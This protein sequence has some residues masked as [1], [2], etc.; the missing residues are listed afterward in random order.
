M[1]PWYRELG[2]DYSSYNFVFIGSRLNEPLLHHVMADTRKGSKRKPQRGYLISPKISQLEQ[3][4]LEAS[5]IVH[6][7]GTLA[8]F[9]S[10]LKAEIGLPPTGWELATAKRPELKKLNTGLPAEQQRALNSIV[11]VGR[12]SLPKTATAAGA[13]RNFYKGFKPSW[14]DILDGVQAD[15][16]SHSDFLTSILSQNAQGSMLALLGPAGSGK[17]TLL[18]ATALSLSEKTGLP[19]YWL[20]EAVF[21]I[22]EVLFTLE[23]LASSPYYLFIDRIDAMSKKIADLYKTKKIRRCT[24][25]FADRQNIWKRRIESQLSEFVCKEFSIDRIDRS[26]VNTILEKIKKFGPWTRLAKMPEREQ[27][28]EIYDRSARQLLI[29]LLEA[30]SGVGFTDIIRRDYADLGNEEHQK[31]VVIVG[32]ATIHQSTIST[33]LAGRAL[34]LCGVGSDINKLAVEVQGIIEQSS[35]ALTARHPVYIR[36]LFERIVDTE[37]IKTCIIALLEAL[38]DYK[39]PVIQNSTKN[40]GIIFKSIINHRFLRRMMRDNESNILEIYENF[41]TTF[42]VDGLYWLQYGLALRGFNRHADALNMFRTAR[43]AYTSPQIEHG[44]AQQ[45]IIIAEEAETWDI[46]EP[47]LQEALVILRAQKLESLDTDTYPIISLAEG[48]VRVLRKHR[49]ESEARDSARTYANELQRL[50]RKI[51]NERLEETAVH[52]TKYAATGV[53][54]EV[55]RQNDVEWD[56]L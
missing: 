43:D 11:V 50:R 24:L 34:A 54:S 26:D 35:G 46:A 1:P 56:P 21:D 28:R 33:N 39:A 10:F 18:M 9:V 2:Q 51:N 41:E 42:H 20:R 52:M 16:K 25:I 19:V 13:I 31:L 49:Q 38:A 22:D 14:G 36:E 15:L 30:T 45:L 47:L 55:K 27:R 40:D 5:N 4:H 7:P 12:S 6:I 3:R 53:W 17:T 23:D 44:Y 8:D 48:H 37:L 32:L 29:G